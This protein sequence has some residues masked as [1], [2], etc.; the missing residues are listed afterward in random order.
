MSFIHFEFLSIEW[1]SVRLSRPAH[2]KGTK[3]AH[4]ILP[5]IPFRSTAG[6]SFVHV[7]CSQRYIFVKAHVLNGVPRSLRADWPMFNCCSHGTLLHFSLQRSRLNIFATTTKIVVFVY[8]KLDLLELFP[9]LFQIY[10]RVTLLPT[11]CFF[12]SVVQ[13]L[14]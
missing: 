2:G 4:T 13:D 6:H 9:N 14:R 8:L 3:T 10:R 5:G 7:S 12:W 1:N 11:T